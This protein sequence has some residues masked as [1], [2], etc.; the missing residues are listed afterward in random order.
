VSQEKTNDEILRKTGAQYYLGSEDELLMKVNIWG[1][2]KTPGQYLVPAGTDLISLISF[3]GGPIQ[4]A[5]MK[6]IKLIRA[7]QDNGNGI[8]K[9]VI[10]VDVKKYIKTG[11]DSLIP[12]L[13]PGDTIVVSGSTIYHL[14]KFFDFASKLALIAQIY[15]WV[16]IAN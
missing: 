1:F 5:K 2:V 6:N 16:K 8:Q 10:N 13:L 7:R 15:F 3:A 4:E 14:G 11:D 9:S 12:E